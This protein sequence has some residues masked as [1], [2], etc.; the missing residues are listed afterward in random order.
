MTISPEWVQAGAQAIR[1]I[2][3]LFGRGGSKG[4]RGPSI[5]QQIQ[6]SIDHTRAHI[7]AVV[8]AAD[9]DWETNYQ[10]SVSLALQLVPTL[11]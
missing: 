8:E 10:L 3:S 7:P 4:A 5:A 9:R 2:G 1:S 6:A 11:D